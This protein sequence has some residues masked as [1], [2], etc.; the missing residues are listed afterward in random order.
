MNLQSDEQSSINLGNVGKIR[1]QLD[2]K[3]KGRYECKQVTIP[4]RQYGADE[5]VKKAIDSLFRY[6]F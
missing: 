4:I 1:K 6:I 5:G 2:G 3:I